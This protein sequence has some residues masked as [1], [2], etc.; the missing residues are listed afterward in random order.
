MYS[1]D[2]ARFLYISWWRH[3]MET[4]SALLALCAGNSPVAGEF[5][6]QRPVTRGF[7]VFFELRLYKR[8]SKQPWGWLF[9]TPS[10]PLWRHCNVYN[11]CDCSDI[12]STAYTQT[13]ATST[14]AT[15][16][17]DIVNDVIRSQSQTVGGYMRSMSN[18]DSGISSTGSV[19]VNTTSNP[20]LT[21]IGPCPS[22]DSDSEDYVNKEVIE[23]LHHHYESTK[24]RH[25]DDR[26]GKRPKYGNTFNMFR[27]WGIHTKKSNGSTPKS[28]HKV[29]SIISMF[30]KRADGKSVASGSSYQD[31]PEPYCYAEH[32]YGDSG[33]Y[34][35]LDIAISPTTTGPSFDNH[36]Y[37]SPHPHGGT[38]SS[39]QMTR[40]LAYITR[41]LE[42]A[43][44]DRDYLSVSGASSR[45]SGPYLEIL[46]SPVAWW[47]YDDVI[48]RTQRTRGV[49][50]TSL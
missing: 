3:Q 33:G 11:F 25:R 35:P 19:G 36:G 30:E 8:L 47:R 23:K 31:M 38:P 50:I 14:S 1:K 22:S 26:R 44:S 21:Q 48:T 27:G 2:D 9:G 20:V 6:S 37:L 32:D 46:E 16:A 10:R 49:M 28:R 43:E 12:P 42:A 7:D 17:C 4:F 34:T 45:S 13:Y 24:S 15:A 39:I 41:T 18:A 40:S 5:R 29:R